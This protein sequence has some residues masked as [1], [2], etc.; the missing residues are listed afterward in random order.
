MA[1]VERP[2]NINRREHEAEHGRVEGV[3][4]HIFNVLLV[5]QIA[6]A[7]DRF[8]EQVELLFNVFHGV[9]G[10]VDFL[11]QLKR[12]RE[13]RIR[14][15][16]HQAPSNTHS[17]RMLVER[18]DARLVFLLQLLQLVLVGVHLFQFIVVFDVEQGA[19]DFELRRMQAK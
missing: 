1:L 7:V 14:P 9:L 12:P 6:H 8:V 16:S 10:V 11:A 5:V 4:F 17:D 13:K 15:M 3:P 2:P 18:F 19:F